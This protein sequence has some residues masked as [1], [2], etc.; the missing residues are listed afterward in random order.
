M[1]LLAVVLLDCE[2]HDE[3]RDVVLTRVE[4]NSEKLGNEVEPV[5]VELYEKEVI[6][7]VLGKYVDVE[8]VSLVLGIV[9]MLVNTQGEEV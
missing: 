9:E 8:D 5:V 4:L 3:T 2:V 1:E 7:V 6:L